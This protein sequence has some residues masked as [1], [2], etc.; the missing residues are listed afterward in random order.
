MAVK[1]RKQRGRQATKKRRPQVAAGITQQEYDRQVAWVQGLR[2]MAQPL[3]LPASRRFST[4]GVRLMHVSNPT[5]VFTYKVLLPHEFK[6]GDTVVVDAAGG[7]LMGIVI[8]VDKVPKID[9]P[10]TYK[11]LRHKVVE[12]HDED[13]DAAPVDET[14]MELYNRTAHLMWSSD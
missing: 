3:E 10:Y 9:G 4:V 11:W 6:P 8:R 2:D 5:R 7:M 13:I 1:K 12:L 14:D